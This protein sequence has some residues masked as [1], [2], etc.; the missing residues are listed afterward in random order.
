MEVSASAN[1]NMCKF[2]P[3]IE[4]VFRAWLDKVKVNGDVMIESSTKASFL[5]V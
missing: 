5:P 3:F 2:Q 4:R 1:S